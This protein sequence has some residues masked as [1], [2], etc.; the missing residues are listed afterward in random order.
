EE[1]PGHYRYLED[2]GARLEAGLKEDLARKGIPHAVN[3]VG[4][5]ITVFFAEGPVVTFQDARRTDTEL[6]KRFFH[7]F[8]DRGIY[9]PPSNFEAAFLSVAHT[10]ED[11][12]R[13]L[14]A[15]G[16]AL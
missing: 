5:M 3:R 12:E 15:L 14:E 8:L 6:F 7:G 4:S 1:N 13:T 2:L 11:V 9:W 10:E 16:E